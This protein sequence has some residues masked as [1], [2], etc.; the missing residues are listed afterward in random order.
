MKNIFLVDYE[1]TG[2]KGIKGIEKLEETDEIYIF[3]SFKSNNISWDCFKK[4]QNLKSKLELMEVKVGT[5]DA[6]DFQ[7]ISFL[8][9]L[10]GKDK[11]NELNF[12]VISEDKGYDFVSDFW[13]E[14]FNLKNIFRCENIELSKQEILIS[15]E[16]KLKKLFQNL[17]ERISDTDFKN[18]YTMIKEEKKDELHNLCQG[19]FK[20]KKGNYVYEKIKKNFF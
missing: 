6:L 9:Y 7:L 15:E 1:N 16:N 12:I 14:K 3:Y 10:V 11:N 2:M 13:R 20:F 8:G 19:L 18:V 5:K 17:G 4:L